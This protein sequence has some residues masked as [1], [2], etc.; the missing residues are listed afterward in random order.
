MVDQISL[1]G[2]Q[3]IDTVIPNIPEG[4][5]IRVE[6]GIF[7]NGVCAAPIAG[8]W[9][10]FAADV[11]VVADDVTLV[12][13][14]LSQQNAAPGTGTI[15]IRDDGSVISKRLLHGEVVSTNNTPIPGAICRILEIKALIG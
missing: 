15:I 13:L 5:G 10:G 11:K 7:A 6:V 4:T 8:D 14:S 3:F 2:T 9:F 12:S 1:A